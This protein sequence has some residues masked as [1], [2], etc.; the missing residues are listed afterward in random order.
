[1]II[2]YLQMSTSYMKSSTF[3]FLS[4]MVSYLP[5]KYELFLKYWL[6]LLDCPFLEITKRQAEQK[7]RKLFLLLLLHLL[8]KGSIMEDYLITWSM[9]HKQ[10]VIGVSSCFNVDF[11]NYPHMIHVLSTSDGLRVMLFQAF[12]NL[13]WHK[14]VQ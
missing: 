5:S 7:E 13:Y 9:P 14:N 3:G 12:Q 2:T 1:M 4:Q 6:F 11:C 8:F 10:Y